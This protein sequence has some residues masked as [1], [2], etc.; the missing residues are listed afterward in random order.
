MAHARVVVRATK[1][2]KRVEL[3]TVDPSP[4]NQVLLLPEP[5]GG[6]PLVPFYVQAPSNNWTIPSTNSAWF[7]VSGT[8]GASIDV[9]WGDSDYSTYSMTGST[10]NLVHTYDVQ[11]PEGLPYEGSMSTDTDQLTTFYCW[12]VP[13]TMPF[14]AFPDSTQQVAFLRNSPTNGAIGAV[15]DLPAG[16]QSLSNQLNDCSGVTGTVSQF[17]SSMTL[18]DF[19][20]NTATNTALSGTFADLASTSYTWLAFEKFSN[21]TGTI[22]S[23][24]VMSNF[25][26]L[27]LANNGSISGSVSNLP[28]STRIVDI[29]NQTGITGS[30]SSL[31][32]SL[33][34]LILDNVATDWSGSISNLPSNLTTLLV[35]GAGTGMSGSINSLPSTLQSLYLN[36]VSTGNNLTGSLSSTLPSNLNRFQVIGTGSGM[37]G[38]DIANLSS[39]RSVELIGFSCSYSYTAG[40][41]WSAS[42]LFIFKVLPAATYGL[43][44]AQVDNILIDLAN[45]DWQNSAT[46]DLSGNNSARSAAS[47]SAVSTLTGMG[48]TVYTN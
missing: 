11:S 45:A 28:S 47:N 4:A 38:G 18:I 27:I 19:Q 31:P 6:G 25:I 30:L 5:T 16:L 46:I 35:S 41:T 15:S 20:G 14:S 36:Q 21:L 22:N 1:P 43:T 8:N 26:C 40:T 3:D 34:T 13:I 37:T 48:V 42:N 9:D 39:C 2:N 7:K 12:D 17:G 10:V 33:R 44:T 24:S 23:L 32:S 29:L